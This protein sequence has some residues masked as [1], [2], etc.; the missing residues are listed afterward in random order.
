[1]VETKSP[2]E[3]TIRWVDGY[4][5]KR[6]LRDSKITMKGL[7]GII[8]KSGISKGELRKI[9]DDLKAAYSSNMVY[10]TKL[11]KLETEC[12]KIGFL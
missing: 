4:I 9:V 7:F 6:F 2:T 12:M 3:S 5:Y 10:M 11:F 8:Q 1:M